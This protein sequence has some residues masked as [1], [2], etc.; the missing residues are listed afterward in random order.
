M[1]FGLNGFFMFIPVTDF[2]PFMELLIESGYI[3]VVK[4]LEIIGGVLLLANRYIGITLLILGPIVINIFLYHLLLDPRNWPISVVNLVLYG[5]LFWD[6]RSLF[7]DFLT[8]NK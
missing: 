1:T 8:P 4:T 5:I 6:N 2:H 3:Y 7:S